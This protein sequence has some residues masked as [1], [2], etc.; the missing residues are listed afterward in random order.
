MLYGTQWITGCSREGHAL[1][2]FI[3]LAGLF[4]P[5]M[6]LLTCI[7]GESYKTQVRPTGTKP[8]WVVNP[9]KYGFSVIRQL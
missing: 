8:I 5:C 3:G 6:L 4:V 9:P 2:M 1:V 7:F